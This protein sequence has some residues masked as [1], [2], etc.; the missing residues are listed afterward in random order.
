MAWPRGVYSLSHVAI[1]FAPDDP[2]YGSSGNERKNGYQ[3]LPLGALQPRGETRVLTVPLSQ[4]MR[5]RH[6]PFYAY[7]EQRVSREIDSMLEAH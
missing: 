5:L 1:P 6:N 4:L 2:V 3:G 7:V